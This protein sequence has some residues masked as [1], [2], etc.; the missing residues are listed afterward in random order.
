MPS[1][2][3]ERWKTDRQAELDKLVRSHAAITKGKKGRQWATEHMNFA[4]IT[5]IVS[6][7]Q[8]YCRDLHDISIDSLVEQMDIADPGLRAIA[9][10][11]FIRKRFLNAGNPTWSNVR[12]DF[13]RI[14][15]DIQSELDDAYKRAKP[16]RRELG[17][18]IAA[19][20]A[21]AHGNEEQLAKCR[22]QQPLTLATANRWRRT[23]GVMASG[24]DRVVGAHLGEMGAKTWLK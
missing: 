18:A 11:V 20:N 24:L 8:G 16:W 19:R 6:E 10:A 2:A 9:R 23:L 5:R 13:S 1:S 21:I 14:G 3:L 7:F 12:E 4:L 15:L 22:E 17:Y